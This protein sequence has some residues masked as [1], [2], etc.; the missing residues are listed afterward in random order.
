MTVSVSPVSARVR[1]SIDPADVRVDWFSRTG[2]GGQHRNKKMN[3]CRVTHSSGLVVTR[4]SRSRDD[5]LRDAMRELERLLSESSSSASR[6][7]VAALV[8]E[9]VGSGMRGDKVRTYRFRDD[10]V[11][12]HRTGQSMRCSE[13][14]QGRAFWER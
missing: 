7:A 2:A 11:E 1:V 12:D 10:R 9:Q 8:R 4:Q 14:M 5:N 13:F 3:S 6:S